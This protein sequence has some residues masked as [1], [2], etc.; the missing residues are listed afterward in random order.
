[1]ANFPYPD[2]ATGFLLCLSKTVSSDV[3]GCLLP[4][5]GTAAVAGN[6]KDML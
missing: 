3:V 4:G 6:G 2:L 1:M 5:G